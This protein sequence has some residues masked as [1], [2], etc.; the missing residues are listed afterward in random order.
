MPDD[1]GSYF[2]R[3]DTD[4]H[5]ETPYGQGTTKA[6]IEPLVPIPASQATLGGVSRRTILRLLD[7]GAS[8]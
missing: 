3:M 5:A 4:S 2:G 6:S 7:F 8:L 1:P